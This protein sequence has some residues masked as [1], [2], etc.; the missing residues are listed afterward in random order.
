MAYP[1]VGEQPQG[2]PG[3]RSP[4]GRWR[5]RR[6]H[7]DAVI[8][9]AK[10]GRSTDLTA[11]QRRYAITMAIRTACFV[12]MAF[13]PGVGRWILLAGACFLPGIAVIL[14]NAVDQ[15]RASQQP[16]EAGM[17][18]HHMALTSEPEEIVS[19]TVIHHEDH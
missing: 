11:R 18:Q 3:G 13:V 7:A 4:A 15:R 14:G 10:H 6:P 17:P 19:G 12:A 9:N 8:T 2:R 16:V 1:A 5:S